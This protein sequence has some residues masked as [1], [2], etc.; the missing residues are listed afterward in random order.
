MRLTRPVRLSAAA[1]AILFAAA[2]VAETVHA[3]D[4]S[5]GKTRTVDAGDITLL[6]PQAWEEVEPPPQ[7]RRFRVAQ[8]NV[9]P[10]KDSEGPAE[11][12]VY[13]FG[14][15]GG[16]VDA[17]LERWIGQFEAEGREAKAAQGESQAGPYVIVEVSGTYNKP[18][19]PPVLGKTERTENS[20]ML[21]VVLAVPDKGNYFLKLTGP[22]ET[23]AKAA[24]GFRRAFG[25]SA[26]KETEYKPKGDS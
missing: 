16:G 2:I 19:G 8:F 11:L 3:D 12:V 9:P 22:K 17:N 24:E 21:A 20:Q 25:G 15:S 4:E 14:G 1:L 5:Q 13:Y 6:V 7:S 18:V 23:V 26:D 10:A